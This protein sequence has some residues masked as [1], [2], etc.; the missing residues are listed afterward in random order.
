M[1]KVQGLLEEQTF[2]D[3]IAADEGLG[4]VETTEK[5]QDLAVLE[6]TVHGKEGRRGNHFEVLLIENAIAVK[7]LG[8]ATVEEGQDGSS[9]TQQVGEPVNDPGN[10]GGIEVIEQVPGQDGIEGVIR[11]LE[12]GA[13]ETLGAGRRG[14]L[15]GLVAQC[16]GAEALLIGAEK[17]FTGKE[18]V[19]GVNLEAALD[20]KS[21][22]GLPDGTEVEQATV[23][24]VP[25]V[26]DEVFEAVGLAAAAGSGDWSRGCDPGNAHTGSA[27]VLQGQ[28]AVGSAA[29]LLKQT[30]AAYECASL[31]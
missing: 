17:I 19:V 23:A 14:E 13:Q 18:Q 31:A 2:A 24:Q 1:A 12:G 4:A 20:E 3:L 29:K 26:S 22:G 21:D 16:E 9:G 10:H 8:A 7:R 15:D 30:H 28:S 6:D 11:V 27:A 5:V 25:K